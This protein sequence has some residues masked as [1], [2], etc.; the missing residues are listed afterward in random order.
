M[1]RL[2]RQGRLTVVDR[3]VDRIVRGGENVSPAEVETVLA[4]HPAIAEACV[5]GIPDAEM[6]HI[7]AAAV[8]LRDGAEDPGDAA[9]TAHVRGLLAR[10]KVP[11]RF[12]RLDALPRTLGGKLRRDAVRALLAG[13]PAGELARPGGDTIGWRVTGAGS[14]RI[15]LLHGTLSNAAQL[16]RLAASLARPGDVTVH[17]LDRRGS[18]SSRL[19]QPRPLDVSVHVD[20]LVAYLDCRGIDRAAVVGVSFGGALALELA[21]RHPDRVAA[22]VAYEPPYGPVADPA[23]QAAFGELAG[24]VAEAHATGGAAAAAETF[25]RA[26][27]GDAAWDRLSPRARAFL[28]HEGD[29]A[30]ADAGLAGLDPDGLARIVAPVTILTGGASEPFYAPIADALAARIPGARRDTLVGWTHTSPITQPGIV[31]AALR[32]CLEPTA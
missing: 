31:A 4:S 29:G 21:A 5:V 16:D 23:T 24:A 2:D 1:G 32:A 6:G 13:D 25:L 17:A 12:I 10:Y 28:E 7:P 30:L 27:A 22:V 19:A 8:V 18:G 14:R 26:V 15:L 11:A 9:L 20:D 3:R